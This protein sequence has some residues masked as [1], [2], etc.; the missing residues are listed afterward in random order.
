MVEILPVKTLSKVQGVLPWRRKRNY[1]I[2]HNENQMRLKELKE[3]LKVSHCSRLHLVCYATKV[4][5]VSPPFLPP[6]PSSPPLLSKCPCHSLVCCCC[7]DRC[8]D[9]GCNSVSMV[10]S[11]LSLLRGFLAFLVNGTNLLSQL[12]K[13]YKLFLKHFLWLIC[14]NISRIISPTCFSAVFPDNHPVTSPSC[15]LQHM[16]SLSWQLLYYLGCLQMTKD[17]S[18]EILGLPL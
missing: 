8:L 9:T 1:S 14:I 18:P 15:F 2:S 13:S 7:V 17:L 6:S 11:F 16:D 10:T 4:C 12:T 3:G 5:L